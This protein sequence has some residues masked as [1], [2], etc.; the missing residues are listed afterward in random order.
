[1]K[2]VAV[3]CPRP[4]WSDFRLRVMVVIICPALSGTNK[5]A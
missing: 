3:A 1:V 4:F 2:S 5:P